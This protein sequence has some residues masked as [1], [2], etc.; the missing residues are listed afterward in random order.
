MH[1]KSLKAEGFKSFADKIEL[2]FDGDITT[3]VGPNGSGKSNISDAVRWVLGEQSAKSLRGAKME[4]V[5]FGGSEK[6]SR[7]GFAEVVL[8]LNNESKIFNSEYLELVISRKVYASGE[9]QYMINGATCRLRD[10]HEIF[11]DTGVGRDGYSIIGQGKVDEILSSKSEDRRILFEEAAGISKYRYKKDEAERKLSHTEDNIIRLSDIITELETQ[12]EPLEKQSKKAKKYLEFKEDLKV[13]EVNSA[14][15]T[16]EKNKEAVKKIIE[17]IGIV[18][19]HLAKIKEEIEGFDAEQEKVYAIFSEYDEKIADFQRQLRELEVNNGIL[20]SEAGVMQNTIDSNNTLSSRINAEIEQSASRIEAL[21]GDICSFLEEKEKIKSQT[22]AIEEEIE[23]LTKERDTDVDNSQKTAAAEQMQNKIMDK[24][25]AIAEHKIKLS[26]FELMISNQELRLSEIYSDIDKKKSELSCA[27]QK[28]TSLIEERDFKQKEILECEEKLSGINNKLRE[29]SVK[30]RDKKKQFDEASVLLMQKKTRHRMLEDMEQNYS[31][32]PK[33]VRLIMK[34]KSDGELEGAKIYGPVSKIFNVSGKYVTAIEAALGSAALNIVVEDENDA[35]CAI[36]YLK[37]AKIGRATFMPVSAIRGRKFEYPHAEKEK[38]FLAV[39]SSLVECD[40][41]FSQI[42]ENLLGRCVVAENID[43]A[44]SISKKYK[45]AFKI[46]T[47]S[48]EVLNAGG[49]M[50]GGYISQNSNILGREQEI[51]GLKEEIEKA[52]K[53]LKDLNEKALKLEAIE[54]GLKE[55]EEEFG[56]VLSNKKAS[57]VGIM[58]DIEHNNT[59]LSDYSG[60]IEKLA[61]DSV[62]I[63]EEIKAFRADKEKTVNAISEEETKIAEIRN[64]LAGIEQEISDS[65]FRKEIISDTIVEKT[66][67]K[68]SLLKDIT[69]LDEKKSDAE[70]E[71]SQTKNNIELRKAEIGDIEK[72]NSQL[73]DEIKKREEELQNSLSVSKK[74]NDEI[75]EC[76][77]V[78]LEHERNS[79]AV[80][81]M[82]RE[83]RDKV[84][85]LTEECGRLEAKKEKLEAETDSAIDRLWD[86]YEITY[87][88]TEKYRKDLGG[89]ATVN[90][91]IAELKSKIRALGNINVD[92]IEEYDAVSKRYEFLSGQRDDLQEAKKDL[93]GIISEMIKEMETRFK[94]EFE[95]IS[96]H[97]KTTFTELFGG[98]TG[99]LSLQ[100]P[101][102]VLESPININVQPPGKKLQSLSLLSGGE[103]ALSAIA[104]LFAIIKIRPTPFCF[105]DEIEAALDEANVYRFADYIKNYSKN[106]QFILIT[107]RRGTM[108]CADTIYGITMQEKGVSKL[109]RLNLGEIT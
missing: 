32:Y 12:I 40:G 45:N 42:A 14:I 3:I 15:N 8:T 96:K 59:V 7:M 66:M 103:R 101:T 76:K 5:I 73:A 97:F 56:E 24:M 60:V 95:K 91:A 52:E 93:N 92:S 44:I 61:E 89:A 70:L 104:L 81:E 6:R 9:S 69:V 102:N 53:T 35:K 83:S 99:E 78:K 41:K 21:R 68:S 22:C 50:S 55:E 37:R 11:M 34:A 51:S 79:I 31:G 108:E 36:E 27:H 105:L 1:I 26:N 57:V 38:G 106:T 84:Y 85:A 63:E 25:S 16:V 94:T 28:L 100:D 19:E 72:K 86:E 74:I 62:N 33:S 23:K 17:D 107:H 54:R 13:Y 98:G 77:K 75:E 90:K 47:L 80:Q 10:I 49:T 65:I 46:V 109:L 48:G 67:E 29:I 39:A 58:H 43:D 20:K 30:L 71:I 4:D 87:S 2:K 82:S 64:Q 18:T 88:E